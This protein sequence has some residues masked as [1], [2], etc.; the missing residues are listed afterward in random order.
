MQIISLINNYTCL[1]PNQQGG[2]VSI[3]EYVIHNLKKKINI[4]FILKLYI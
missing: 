2:N 1:T 3:V 4:I